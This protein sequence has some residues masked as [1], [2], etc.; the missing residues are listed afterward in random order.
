M[1]EEK[2]AKVNNVLVAL[3]LLL[4]AIED[5]EAD[6]VFT[7]KVK[8]SSNRLKADIEKVYNTVFKNV[9]T[10]ASDYYVDMLEFLKQQ[11]LIFSRFHEYSEEDKIK[12]LSALQNFYTINLKK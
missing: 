11:G 7:Q 2:A 10:I 8:Q 9:S 4:E 3:Q 12:F 5:A 6:G 1:T